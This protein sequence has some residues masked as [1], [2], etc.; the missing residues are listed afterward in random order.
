MGRE[1]IISRCIN[2]PTFHHQYYRELFENNYHVN[3][4]MPVKYEKLMNKLS[5]CPYFNMIKYMPEL[6]KKTSLHVDPQYR[7]YITLTSFLDGYGNDSNSLVRLEMRIESGHTEIVLIRRLES[8]KM[9]SVFLDYKYSHY[10]S[11]TRNKHSQLY[12]KLFA[13]LLKND[14]RNILQEAVVP[15][16]AFDFDSPFAKLDYPPETNCIYF[17]NNYGTKK[18]FDIYFIRD[19]DIN[20]MRIVA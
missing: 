16:E 15:R 11:Q 9:I 6:C 13:Y 7:R 8:T 1:N 18:T 17:Y 14:L 19:K 2:K 3:I 20:N 12:L 10:E 4:S 5:G